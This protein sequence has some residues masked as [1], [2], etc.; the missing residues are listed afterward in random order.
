MRRNFEEP[1]SMAQCLEVYSGKTSS[2]P[3]GRRNKRK[4]KK[5][6]VAQ[7]QGL[8]FEEPS[9]INAVQ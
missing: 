8:S 2:G 5:V 6:C 4:Q 7:V 9:Q 1:I 3:Q